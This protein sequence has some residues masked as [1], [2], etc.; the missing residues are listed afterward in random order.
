MDQLSFF[1]LNDRLAQISKIGDPLEVLNEIVDWS[2]FDGVLLEAK[3]KD[4]TDRRVKGNAGRKPFNL[5]LMLKV[6]V[7]QSLY[8]LSDDQMEYQIKDRLSFMRFLDLGLNG[9]VPDAKTIWN[10]REMFI[11]TGAWEKLFRK[12]DGMLEEKGLFARGGSIVDATIVNVPVQ[13]N[14]ADENET[15]KKGKEP[16]E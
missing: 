11:R 1:D 7:L 15:I 6:F 4:L 13:R 5:R 3:A 8:N 12:F 16:E 9:T 10:Y 14:K 2:K